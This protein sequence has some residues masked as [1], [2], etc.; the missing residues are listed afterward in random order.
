MRNALKV[1]DLGKMVSHRNSAPAECKARGGNAMGDAKDIARTNEGAA[2][3]ASPPVGNAS[4]RSC[5]DN[6]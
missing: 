4:E 1:S 6:R 2:A 5:T 3:A